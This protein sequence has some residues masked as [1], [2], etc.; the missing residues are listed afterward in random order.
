M[1]AASCPSREM[2]VQY[3]RGLL[4]AEPSDDLAGHLGSCAE[5]QATIA[6]L[7][8][9]EDTLIGRL[10]RPLASGSCLAEPEYQAAVARAIDIMRASGVEKVGLITAR[11]EAGK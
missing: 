3:S 10:R 6:S 11:L 1:V 5:C 7:D 9:A 8:D 2:L 4:A